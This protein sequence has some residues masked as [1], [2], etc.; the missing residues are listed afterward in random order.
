M[1]IT[2]IWAVKDSLSRVIGYAE[3]SEKTEFS[4]M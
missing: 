3:N 4:D 2:K 1:G